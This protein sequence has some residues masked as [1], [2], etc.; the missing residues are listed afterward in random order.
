MLDTVMGPKGTH[1]FIYNVQPRSKRPE[2]G[3]G[4]KY[5][6]KYP[7]QWTL[8]EWHV[9]FATQKRTPKLSSRYY[10]EIVRLNRVV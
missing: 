7:D 3:K 4:S 10:S 6:Y 9:D 1:Q 8:A 2:F 5:D